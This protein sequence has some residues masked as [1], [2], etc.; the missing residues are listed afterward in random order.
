MEPLHNYSPNTG[1]LQQ[2]I[3][4]KRSSKG[5]CFIKVLIGLIIAGAIAA[6]VIYFVYTK[7][8]D[9]MDKLGETFDDLKNKNK[10]IGS[11]NEDK[12]F[13]GDFVDAVIVPG[14]DGDKIF[15]LMDASKKYIET[16]KTPGRYST[17]VACIDCKTIMYVYDPKTNTIVN[18]TELK[19]PDV[20]GFSN[21]AFSDGKVYHFMKPYGETSAGINTYNANTGE[22]LSETKE[23]ISSFPELSQGIVELDYRTTNRTVRFDTKDGR[24]NIV[25]SVDRN[26][27]FPNEKEM[28]REIESSVSGE[29][30]MFALASPEK[31]SRKQLYKITAPKTAILTD[32]LALS[33]YVHSPGMLKN[34]KASTEKLSDESY[35]EGIIYAQDEDYVFIVSVDEYGKKANR[36]FTCV[37]ARTGREKWS[38]KQ[39]E[40]FDSFK[41]DEVQSSTQSFS[42]TKD[43]ISV[44]RQGNTV[45]L[46]Y[47]GDGLI[48]FDVNTGKK[49]WSVQPSPVG[50]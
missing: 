16:K 47:K 41:I 28:N 3:Y 14:S 11:R 19:Y 25:Y 49:L 42:S 15:M 36:I 17:G 27:I 21:I 1:R 23:F 8:G 2:S 12:R 29:G 30:Y 32:Q 38:V 45:I 10:F 13:S 50:L 35:I 6:A 33:T 48:G 31:D 37:D 18:N 24:K 40:L 34:Y 7:L 44:L 39:A 43:N 9:R 46:K 22:L 5:G 26:K 4:G 20:I